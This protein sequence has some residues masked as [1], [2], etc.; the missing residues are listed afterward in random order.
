MAGERVLVVDDSLVYRDL[1]VNH[2]LTPNG[3]E[4]LTANDGES[5]L[6]IALR[7]G[8]D[9]II[10]DMQMP[11]MT[12]LQVLEALHQAGSEIPVIMMTLHGSEDLAVRAFRLG[13]KDYVIKPF[14]IEEMLIA[15]DRALTEVRLRRERDALTRTLEAERRQLEAVL[16]NTKEGILLVDDSD[17]DRI[18]LANHAVCEAFN[19]E[20][21]GA[22]RPLMEVVQDEVLID[23]FQQAKAKAEI[24]H[25]ELPLPDDRTFNANI[26]PIQ[27]VGRVAVMQD[28]TYLKEL[29]R[30]KS[31]F[32]ST[33][34]H[35]LRSPLTSVKGFAD[36]LPQV[37]QLNE[38]QA[39]FLEKIR[40]G[41]DT[42]TEMISDLLDLGRIEA[43]VRM[44]LEECDLGV[45]IE[46]VIAGQR[47][48]A[49]LKKQ[50]LR[51]QIG[52]DLPSV[53]GN[54][55]RLGQAL[56][57]LVSNAIK[58]TAEK[59]RISVIASREDGQAVIKIEDNG[60]GIPQQDLPHIFDKFYRVDR[61]E[62]EGIIGSGLGLSIVKTI[63]EKHRGRIWVDSKMGV[64][65]A[66]TIVLPSALEPPG[67]TG[68][69][70]SG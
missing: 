57:N 30:M 61:P 35:D 34:S 3:Y 52:P 32:V 10:M 14:D 58:Y 67:T 13:V 28:I 8:P 24:A 19:L 27:G 49:E 18:I 25:A 41:V 60:M 44:D 39:Y 11:G 62:T 50:Y 21:D 43:E 6:R 40:S 66:F 23:V 2:V 63:I 16:T 29:D 26:T 12:G 70:R 4:P 55:V 42:V 53:L 38:Q 47:N 15:M 68:S 59:G 7:E 31:E 46:K 1:L 65:T 9:L 64:G 48:H 37:G 69:K 45:I 22:N 51:M 33:V 56:S 36:L 17:E 54:P 5:G 20:S